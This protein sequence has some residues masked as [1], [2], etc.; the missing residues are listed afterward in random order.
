MLVNARIGN[1]HKFVSP[2]VCVYG[3]E[4]EGFSGWIGGIAIKQFQY[5]I[6]KK[7]THIRL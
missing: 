3:R 1:I 7:N 4:Q 2:I 5:N 6:Y